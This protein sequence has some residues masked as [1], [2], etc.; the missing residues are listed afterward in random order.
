MAARRYYPIFLNLKG[1][2]VLL[3][4]GG[5]VALRKAKLFLKTGAVLTIVSKDFSESFQ[6]F[7]KAHSLGLKRG[8]ALGGSLRKFSL[9]VSATSDTGFNRKIYQ[10]CLKENI[11]VNVVDN[12][13]HSTFIVPSSL[14]R[15]PLEIAISTGGASPLLAKLIRKMLGRQFGSEYRNMVL[16]L[17]K[18]RK[19]VKQM[20][21]E[22]KERRQ[23]F[24][25]LIETKFRSILERSEGKKR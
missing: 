1:R 10:K 9:V 17:Q 16:W 5:S 7:A 15:G 11:F 23:H 8:Y 14:K 2:Y 21:L 19:K 24:Q 18:E 3:F 4:G 13:Q 22:Q 6:T 20:I 25:K 12:P